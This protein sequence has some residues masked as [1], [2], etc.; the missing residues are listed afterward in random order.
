MATGISALGYA[1]SGIRRAS[2]LADRAASDVATSFH[3]E[4]RKED[5]PAAVTSFSNESR[6]LASALIDQMKASVLNEASVDILHTV[7]EMTQELLELGARK[8]P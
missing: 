5:S 1:L 6:E 3:P 8:S 7:D 4:L 2:N